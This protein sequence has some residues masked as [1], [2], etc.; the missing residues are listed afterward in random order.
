MIKLSILIPSLVSRNKQLEELR[1]EI[2]RQ[3]VLYKLRGLVE[4]LT[5]VD[6]G[7]LSIGDK[8]NELM[9]RA[10]G[11]YVCYIDDDDAIAKNYLR[12]IFS[13]ITHHSPDCC[14]LMGVI[15][16]DGSNPEL[17]VHSIRY[18]EYKTNTHGKPKYERYPNHLNVIKRSIASKYKFPSISH[19]EDTDFATQVFKSGDIKT[20]AEITD[21][22]YYYKFK[23]VK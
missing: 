14:S 1:V 3:E 11:E 18:K 23:T 4:V 21:I 9:R 2:Q 12:L 7:E 20:E 13:E 5:H 16:W 10:K 22:L 19:G 8:R 6:S 17:F 15:T